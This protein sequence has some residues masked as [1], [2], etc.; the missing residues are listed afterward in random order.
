MSY[1]GGRST[2][3]GS[4]RHPSHGGGRTSSRPM[5][6]FAVYGR[7]SSRRPGADAPT[8]DRNNLAGVDFEPSGRSTRRASS[9][10]DPPFPVEFEPRPGGGDFG[11]RAEGTRASGPASIRASG[12]AGPAGSQQSTRFGTLDDGDFVNVGHK[13]NSASGFVEPPNE[14]GGGQRSEYGGGSTNGYG[15]Y[16]NTQQFTQQGGGR[17]EGGS[18]RPRGGGDGSGLDYWAGASGLSSGGQEWLA[19]RMGGR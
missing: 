3:Q 18:T 16:V 15:Q 19:R 2:R 5:P 13:P 12:P 4:T 17:S 1:S 7:P 9:R 10:R 8:S 14:G 11:P 6:P